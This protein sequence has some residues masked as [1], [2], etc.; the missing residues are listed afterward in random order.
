MIGARVFLAGSRV[1]GWVDLFSMDRTSDGRRWEYTSSHARRM[2]PSHW[3]T[4]EQI[5]GLHSRHF[6][7]FVDTGG[8]ER[9]LTV[10]CAAESEQYLERVYGTNW[11]IPRRQHSH[12]LAGYRESLFVPLYGTT[13]LLTTTSACVY[14]CMTRS[15]RLWVLSAKCEG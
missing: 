2:W 7:G 14:T 13:V 8:C 12:T 11:T 10:Q 9:T 5:E 4:V 3:F 1:G 6:G 15:R